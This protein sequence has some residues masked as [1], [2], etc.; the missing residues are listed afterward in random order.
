MIKRRY[1]S[2]RLLK[3]GMVIDQSI[4]DRTGRALVHRKTALDNYIIDSLRKL[5]ITGVYIREGEEDPEESN[6]E[7]APETRETIQKLSVPDRAKIQL[8]ESVKKRVG[9]GVQYLFSNP[10]SNDFVSTA[11]NI[12]TDLMKA[13]MENDAIAV[14]IGAL[15]LSDEYTF[16]HSVDVASIAMIIAK[17]YGFS[18]ED[19]YKIGITGLLH[20]VGK[21]Q[22]PNEIL[23]KPDKLTEEEFALMKKHSLFGYIILKKKPD[24][25]PD[26]LLGVLQHHEK[27]NGKGYPIGVTSNTICPFARILAVADIYD[28]LVTER[29]YKK[30]FT[31]RDATEMI[32]AMSHELDVKAIQS[33]LES[34]LLYPLGTV[35]TLSNG[36][37]AKV[38]KNNEGYP[39]RPKIVAL[40][41]GK[42]YD[43][44]QVECASLII[45]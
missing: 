17:N 3:E 6:I 12:S 13:I 40:H 10:D 37:K 15:K 27:M 25:T 33:F 36:E 23:N 21:S 20:D 32:M 2:I 29:P 34:V 1:I 7:V 45:E 14:D 11:D 30:A 19:V 41:S 31:Q 26:I 5:G 42:V 4:I 39:L 9:T 18:Q 24:I 28:A 35:V 22:I 16:Q 43:L 38:V 8:S 44:S